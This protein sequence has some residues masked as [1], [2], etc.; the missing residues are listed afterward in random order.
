MHAGSEESQQGIWSRQLG[1]RS[2]LDCA[3]VCELGILR[4][5]CWPCAE[6]GATD[7]RD[8]AARSGA[9]RGVLV[10]FGNVADDF[11]EIP[12]RSLRE[13]EGVVHWDRSLRA[14][15]DRDGPASV[16]VANA[17]VDSSKGFRIFV[18]RKWGRIVEVEF[19]V[20]SHNPTI[21]PIQFVRNLERSA[22][23]GVRPWIRRPTGVQ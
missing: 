22:R 17:L 9:K 2:G 14:S 4:S 19:P 18:V 3:P 1:S 23:R 13:P 8:R 10:I 5:G 16:G 20:L 12:Q 21:A 15:L 7:P 11:G 6:S